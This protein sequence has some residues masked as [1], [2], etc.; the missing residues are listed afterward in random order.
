MSAIFSSNKQA[1]WLGR[2]QPPT[3]GHLIATLAILARW[4]RLTIGIVHRSTCPSG[5]DSRWNKYLNFTQNINQSVIRNPFQPD[6]IVN[7]WK[8]T[9]DD[10]CISHRVRLIN[11]PQTAY[12]PYFNSIYPV[13]K[14]D[15]VDIELTNNDPE[16]DHIRQKTFKEV[17]CRPIEY[18]RT[19][20]KIHVS[21]LRNLIDQGL[22]SWG[23][24][25]PSGGYE[26]FLNINGP[27]RMKNF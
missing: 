6:E 25:I 2:F 19:P 22:I 9:L 1:L 17:L 4:R 23:K 20:W 27:A 15:F 12:Q 26:Y 13:E 10:Q 16:T 14:Y 11:M 5:I 18:V 8:A 3:K 21:E 7:M 24:Y